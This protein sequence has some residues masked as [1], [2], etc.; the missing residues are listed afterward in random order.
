MVSQLSLAERILVFNQ[1]KQLVSAQLPLLEGIDW[2]L[3]CPNNPRIDETLKALRIAVSEGRTL[4]DALTALSPRVGRTIGPLI[5]AGESAGRLDLVLESWTIQLKNEQVQKQRLIKAASY[6]LTILVIATFM[7]MG[8]LVWVVPQ[9]ESLFLTFQ[10]PLPILTQWIIQTSQSLRGGQWSLPVA[11]LVILFA[12]II[13]RSGNG[14]YIQSLLD[15]AMR[16]MPPIRHLV[17]QYRWAQIAQ[18]LGLLLQ[19]GIQLQDALRMIT[20]SVQHPCQN[21][22]LKQIS[23]Q[24]ERG[25]TLNEAWGEIEHVDLRLVQWTSVGEKT[26]RLAIMMAQAGNLLEDDVN[27]RLEKMSQMLE[28]F[29]M[30]CVGMIV[31][32]FLI[33][34]YLPMFQLTAG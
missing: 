9:F 27:L 13:H 18:R 31:G 16:L 33:G 11:I 28:P 32:T 8:L 1:L 22:A 26:G 24:L 25:K 2:M 14:R 6:P 12:L 20:E 3:K 17:D 4:G 19:S 29:M 23:G 15:R 30:V 34:L 10:K 7:M 21:M 5:V